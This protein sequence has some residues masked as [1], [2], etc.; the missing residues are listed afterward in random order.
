MV[1]M[2]NVWPMRWDGMEW[3][4]HALYDIVEW[5]NTDRET[6]NPRLNRP[7][8]A[9]DRPN[10]LCKKCRRPNEIFDRRFFANL[11]L[12]I[13]LLYMVRGSERARLYFWFCANIIVRIAVYLVIVCG[14]WFVDLILV[15]LLGRSLLIACGSVQR[16]RRRRRTTSGEGRNHW[17]LA[18]I[19]LIPI[20]FV[21]LCEWVS[22]LINC[23]CFTWR[24]SL[25]CWRLKSGR[26]CVYVVWL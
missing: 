7:S 22:E 17:P 8:N 24:R 11:N 14:L 23:L 16:W 12:G 21:V 6:S 4:T 25:M 18:N 1:R 26:R 5:L 13:G 3:G 15:G 19:N 2:V 20:L 9:A 10:P